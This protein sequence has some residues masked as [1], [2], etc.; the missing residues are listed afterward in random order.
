MYII[1]LPIIALGLCSLILPVHLRQFAGLSLLSAF[2][3][4]SIPSGLRKQ[5]GK[6]G[7]FH[8]EVSHGL[9]SI[10]TGGRFHRFY[11]QPTGGGECLTIGGKRKYIVSAGYIG[12]ILFGALYI[13]NSVQHESMVTMLYIIALLYCISTI[14]AGNLHTASIG[15]M[16]GAV[17]GLVTH[18]APDTI[19]LRLTLNLIGM[20]LIYEGFKSLWQLNIL[21]AVEVTTGSDAEAMSRIVGGKPIHWA[22]FYSIVAVSI[23]LVVVRYIVTAS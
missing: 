10:L 13:A 5:L 18:I 2:I 9:V 16:T 11:V 17:V 3:L 21:S 23:L 20:I 15:L 6:L 4:T 1:A 14:K 12:T 8:H 19:Y 22:L 7:T